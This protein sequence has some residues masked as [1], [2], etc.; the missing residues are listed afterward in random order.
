[1][2]IFIETKYTKCRRAQTSW[3]C[4]CVCVCVCVGVMQILMH[5]SQATSPAFI[6]YMAHCCSFMVG[7]LA[8]C[9][10]FHTSSFHM[11]TCLRVCVEMKHGE[12]THSLTHSL[13]RNFSTYQTGPSSRAHDILHCVTPCQDE[14]ERWR[15]VAEISIR[16][17]TSWLH[18]V[19]SSRV[20]G[21]H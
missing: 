13:T 6:P 11:C 18:H 19:V 14:H 4:V 2:F 5:T 1:M 8:L 3:R 16:R 15:L 9:L 7:M 17:T 21:A 12:T 20:L 10:T